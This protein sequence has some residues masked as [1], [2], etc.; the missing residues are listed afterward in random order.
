MISPLLSSGQYFDPILFQFGYLNKLTHR[1]PHLLNKPLLGVN[2][3][4]I[5]NNLVL[6]YRNYLSV[7]LQT[8]FACQYEF[9]SGDNVVYEHDSSP[10]IVRGFTNIL[11][12]LRQA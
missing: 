12:V 7:I 10:S 3:G 6:A 1:F 5:E 9:V 11:Y 8:E 2:A 4:E